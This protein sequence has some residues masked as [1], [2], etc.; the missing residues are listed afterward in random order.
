MVIL[1]MA[2]ALSATAMPVQRQRDECRYEA[3]RTATER[4]GSRDQLQLIARSGSL[5]IIGRRGAT[6]VRVRGR[7]CASSR[8]LLDQLQVESGHSGSTVRIEVPELRN[9]EWRNNQY[10]RLDL[11]V[12]VPLGMAADIEDGSGETIIEGLGDITV[13]DGSGS[14]HI[15]DVGSADIRD[16]SGEIEVDGVQ[17]DLRITDGSG[18]ISVDKVSG[19]VV[20]H[21]GSGA[22][23]I[24]GAGSVEI[25]EDGS[26]SIDVRDVRGDLTVGRKGSGSIDYRD[27][28]GRVDVP[29]RHRGRDRRRQNR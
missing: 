20:I 16:G 15:T 18:G 5:R 17:G 19:R 10:A 13:V 28:R 11:E 14:L 25:P 9:D 27:V 23:D 8:D 2:A 29:D 12:E 3:E 4:A 22:I 26:G 6:E 24:A 21:D 7:A 1:A